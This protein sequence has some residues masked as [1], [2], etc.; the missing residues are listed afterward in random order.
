MSECI[1]SCFLNW[2]FLASFFIFVFSI[3]QMFNKFCR[4]LDLNSGPLVSET[5]ALPTEPQPLPKGIFKLC[6]SLGRRTHQV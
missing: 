6:L 2:P 5:T 3:Q 4:W 1:L